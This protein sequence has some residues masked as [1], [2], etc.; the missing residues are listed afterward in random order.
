MSAEKKGKWAFLHELEKKSVKDGKVVV[1]EE[2]IYQGDKGITI[3]YYHKEGDAKEKIRISGSGESYKM[4]VTDKNGKVSESEL[5]KKEMLKE[6]SS[7]KKLEFAKEFASVQ[8]GGAL[9]WS[10]PQG[11]RR[12]SSK[13]SKSK[14]SKG[15]KRSKSSKSRR[16]NLSKRK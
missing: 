3:K 9:T 1:H 7:N 15:S 10:R 4:S 5:N 2:K 8:K 13:K 12:R 16:S 6:L 14:G 11:S